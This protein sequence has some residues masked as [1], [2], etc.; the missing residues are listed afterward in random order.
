MRTANAEWVA[1]AARRWQLQRQNFEM[2][3][4]EHHELRTRCVTVS[5]CITL[6]GDVCRHVYPFNQANVDAVCRNQSVHSNGQRDSIEEVRDGCPAQSAPTKSAALIS[7]LRC[8]ARCVPILSQQCG[9]QSSST[10]D[11]RTGMCGERR[12]SEFAAPTL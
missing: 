11:A 7:S 12:L 9:V 10:A 3:S 4:K 2:M 5:T 6:R 8:S 1:T